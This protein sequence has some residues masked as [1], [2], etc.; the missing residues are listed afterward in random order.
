MQNKLDFPLFVLKSNV[1]QVRSALHTASEPQ[2]KSIL[3]MPYHERFRRTLSA[4]VIGVL[5]RLCDVFALSPVHADSKCLNV[6]NRILNQIIRSGFGFAFEQYE[7]EYNIPVS[8]GSFKYPQWKTRQKDI[9]K[10]VR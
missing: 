7:L 8:Q 3:G 1:T 5:D 9:W 10:N 6:P 4:A 2:M